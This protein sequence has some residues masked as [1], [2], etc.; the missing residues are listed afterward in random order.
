MKKKLVLYC[1]S[2]LLI[3]MFVGT[4]I[5]NVRADVESGVISTDNLLSDETEIANGYDGEAAWKLM[6][7]GTLHILGGEV[8]AD[9]ASFAY[10]SMDDDLKPTVKKVVFD[11][12]TIAQESTENFFGAFQNLVEIDNL[13]NLDTSNTTDMSKMFSG[14]KNLKNADFSQLDVSNVTNMSNM[15]SNTG[16]ENVDI[17]KWDV[18][19]VTSMS[20]MFSNSNIKSINASNWDLKSAKNMSN[21][22]YQMPELEMVDVSNWNFHAPIRM[23]NMFTN[24]KSLKSLDLSSWH[25]SGS[26]FSGSLTLTSIT[27]L[28][29]SNDTEL[30]NSMLGFDL[31]ENG[32]LQP[33][34]YLI[35][36]GQTDT[37]LVNPTDF[38]TGVTGTYNYVNPSEIK[39]IAS[40]ETSRGVQN[41][42]VTLA[43]DLTQE[44]DVKVPTIKGATSD[45]ETV[46]GKVVA[47]ADGTGKVI[48]SVKIIDPQGAGYITYSDENSGS[49]NGSNGSNSS[50]K[51][52]ITDVKRLITIHPDNNEVSLYQKDTSEIRNRSLAGG[53]DWY[54][55]QQMVKKGKIYYR[56]STNEWVKAS[57]AYAYES[58]SGI[59]NTNLKDYQLLTTSKGKQVSNR[60]LAA[61]TS[62]KIDRLAYINGNEYYRVSTNEFVPVNEI[63]RN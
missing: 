15:F 40:F 6:S 35:K 7:D 59:I 21:M 55:D 12:A 61:N 13:Q 53:S 42:E 11:G 58:Q 37:D 44:V 19:S 62:W 16:L 51:P 25:N 23:D 29:V 4:G 22:F 34:G 3:T 30:T 47:T 17:S 10:G 33:S 49:S 32:D 38:N 36:S 48:Y 63:K 43:G 28:K 24:D 5:T 18:S 50:N 8:V 1:S 56:V 31:D 27:Q 14:L 45:K 60:A 52:E 41:V 20:N 26:S 39:A 54:S 2:A 9:G 57:D 46:K